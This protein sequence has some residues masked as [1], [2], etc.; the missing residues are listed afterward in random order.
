MIAEKL[1]VKGIIPTFTIAAGGPSETCQ[2][3]YNFEKRMDQV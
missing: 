3:S 2:K 1:T